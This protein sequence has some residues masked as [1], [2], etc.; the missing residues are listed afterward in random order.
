MASSTP[1]LTACVVSSLLTARALSLLLCT[2]HVFP[3]LLF[4]FRIGKWGQVAKSAISGQRHLCI[5]LR[6][7]F[8]TEPYTKPVDR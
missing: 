8:N 2:L 3:L 5:E 4:D 7:S 6:H 1:D